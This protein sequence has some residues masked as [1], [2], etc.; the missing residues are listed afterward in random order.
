MSARRRRPCA[1][2]R[3][4]G[5]ARAVGVCGALRVSAAATG[6]LLPYQRDARIAGDRRQRIIPMG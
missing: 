5:T 3:R 4:D 2:R 6:E 1:R